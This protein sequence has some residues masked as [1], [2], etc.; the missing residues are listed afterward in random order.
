[1]NAFLGAMWSWQGFGVGSSLFLTVWNTDN[2]QRANIFGGSKS[3]GV[4][5]IIFSLGK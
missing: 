4:C 5:S 3:L 1:M 2:E